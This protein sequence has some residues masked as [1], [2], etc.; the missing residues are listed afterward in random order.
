MSDAQAR[1][2]PP[3]LA[4]DADA[5]VVGQLPAPRRRRIPFLGSER[6]AVAQTSRF[7]VVGAVSA[8]VDFGIFNVLHFQ[9]GVGPLTAKTVA[10]TVATLFS[11]WG[12][13]QWAFTSRRTAR[14]RQDLPVFALLN[15]IGL[16]IALAVLAATRYWLGL[17]GA[18][19]LNVV[20]NGGGVV[21]A[22]LFR[23]AAYRAWVFRTPDAEPGMEREDS[24]W[25]G[26]TAP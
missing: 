6:Q 5:P 13:R 20:G 2:G 8:V 11:Y 9:A 25:A 4:D 17:T 12:N 19:A 18:L 21:L 16:L 23:F 7:A 1:P 14:H 26:A 15:G 24:V 22:M 3:P 10:V